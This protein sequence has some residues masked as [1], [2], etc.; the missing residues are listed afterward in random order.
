[1]NLSKR[2]KKR[3]DKLI[4]STYY[5]TCSGIEIGLM[6][7]GKVFAAGHKALAEGA[8]LAQTIVAFVETIR[9]N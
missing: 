1:M 9:Q 6:D 2:E 3:R 8:N 7:I 4:E 5:A